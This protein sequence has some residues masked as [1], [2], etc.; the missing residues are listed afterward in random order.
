MR[1]PQ[2]VRRSTGSIGFDRIPIDPDP[3]T[4]KPRL[5][6][7]LRAILWTCV[8]G[9]AFWGVIAWAVVAGEGWALRFAMTQGWLT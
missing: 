7:S 6:M 2:L 4:L 1:Q 3:P 5:Q 9:L 8:V